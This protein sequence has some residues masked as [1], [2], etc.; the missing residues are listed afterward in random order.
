MLRSNAYVNGHGTWWNMAIGGDAWQI[1]D[2]SMAAFCRS[3]GPLD[4][5]TTPVVYQPYARLPHVTFNVFD[6]LGGFDIGM[7]SEYTDFQRNYSLTGRRLGLY[8]HVSFPIETLG[9]FFRP[10]LGYRFTQYELSDMQFARINN[11]LLK[12]SSS[13]RSLPIFSIDSGLFFERDTQLFGTA[14]IQT[15][16]PRLFYLYV[17]Y[18]DQ[19]GLPVFDTALPSLDFPSLFRTNSFTGGDRQSDANRFTVALTSRLI[20]ADSGDQWLSGSIGQIR[21]LQTPRVGLPSGPDPRLVGKDLFAELRVDINKRWSLTW[22]QQWNPDPGTYTADNRFVAN[23]K[24]TDLSAVSLQHRFG[25]EGVI[26]LAYRYRRGFLDQYDASALIPLNLRWSLI[27]RYYYSV[28]DRRPLESFAGFQ[29]DSC[30]V[31]ARLVARRWINN[32]SNIR[33]YDPANVKATNAVFFEVEFKGI[34]SS[35]QRTQ[36]FLRRAIL[37]YQ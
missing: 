31:A 12:N 30:C 13:S 37:G 6:H 16:E 36:N 24:H 5:C 2:P 27:G 18:R 10:T 7:E 3:G 25:G 14:F 8:P 21:Y 26:N 34:G 28:L 4:G 20:D 9:W 22:D 1:S 33:N 11:P 29:Y 17:P 23:G 15:L 35:G 19:S 32:A